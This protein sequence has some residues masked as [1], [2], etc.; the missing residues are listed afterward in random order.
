MDEP[1]GALDEIISDG[2]NHLHLH[3]LW[4]SAG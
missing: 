2:L 1:F 3:R 4:G